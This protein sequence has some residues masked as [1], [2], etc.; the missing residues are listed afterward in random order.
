MS[1]DRLVCHRC[2]YPALLPQEKTC[3]NDD[4]HLIP[5]AEHRK[6]PKDPYLGRTVGGRYPLLGLLGGEGPGLMYRSLQLVTDREVALELF[7]AERHRPTKESEQRFLREARGLARLQHPAVATLLDFGAEPD[8]TLFLVLELVQGRPLSRCL[9]EGGIAQAELL[10]IALDELDALDVAHRQGIIHRDLQPQNILVLPEEQRGTRGARAR[11][12]GFGLGRLLTTAGEPRFGA[13]R[14][15]AAP[16]PYL[17]PEQAHGVPP[18]RRSNI[19]SL[20]AI[21]FS[22]LCGHPPGEAE[23]AALQTVGSGSTA[24]SAAP[25]VMLPGCKPLAP[26][27]L[28]CLARGLA[29][30]PDERYPSAR[31]MA[32]ALLAS[33]GAAGPAHPARA[34][35]ASAGISLERQPTPI[36]PPGGQPGLSRTGTLPWKPAPLEAQP[37]AAGGVVP[38]PSCAL[39]GEAATEPPRSGLPGKPGVVQPGGPQ[40]G[41]LGQVF[42]LSEDGG[43]RQLAGSALVDAVST[44]RGIVPERPDLGAATVGPGRGRLLS[45]PVHTPMIEL[46]DE[47]TSPTGSDEPPVGAGAVEPWPTTPA[48]LPPRTGPMTATETGEDQPRPQGTA[49]APVT[50]QPPEASSAAGEMP[51]PL[52]GRTAAPAEPSA[53]PE[54]QP[55][56]ARRLPWQGAARP[57]AAAVPAR[58]G[59]LV[60]ATA[61]AA[62]RGMGALNA[63]SE[64]AGSKAGLPLLKYPILV[65]LLAIPAALLG[66][67]GYF[68]VRSVQEHMLAA[69]DAAW[70]DPAGPSGAAGRRLGAP[71]RTMKQ[72]AAALLAEAEARLK[73]GQAREASALLVE[74]LELN[75]D[76]TPAHHMLGMSLLGA[77]QAIEA[78]QHLRQAMQASPDPVLSGFGLAQALLAQR[79]N[80]DAEEILLMLEKRIQSG[81]TQEVPDF[82]LVLG[83][84]LLQRGAPREALMRLA[85]VVNPQER[86]PEPWCLAGE[87]LS[88]LGQHAKAIEFYGQAVQHDPDHV[89]AH[90]GLARTYLML[91]T[92]DPAKATKEFQRVIALDPERRFPEARKGLAYLYRDQGQRTQ[93]LEMLRSYLD[94]LAPDARDRSEVLREIAS[95]EGRPVGSY[96]TTR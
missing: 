74:A 94:L 56:A 41:S 28:R 10:E 71:T 76:L 9:A 13:E 78:E 35:A 64:A 92:P 82:Y 57:P 72:E 40:F 18:D 30:E 17:A 79:R 29:L 77:G 93:A 38:P 32:S 46:V 86:R 26:G 14:A 70:L 75:P 6:A 34:A 54:G 58:A 36:P 50:Y 44:L 3:P 47:V 1:K 60:A 39:P 21:L 65:L 25:V 87:A 27:L 37:E 52:S 67:M 96:S 7:P 91:S 88:Q 12:L 2:G 61:A 83:R 16:T 59:A 45:D 15:D 81:P 48:A 22:A 53:Q 85:H 89:E 66:L 73:L 55:A 8:G 19:Y 49:P 69:E 80:M 31:E 51:S 42:E 20:S 62:R 5:E 43:F 33:T 84:L 90:L 95:L 4:L 68:V 23:R 11:L 24:A 63:M